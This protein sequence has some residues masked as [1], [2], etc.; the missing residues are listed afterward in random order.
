MGDEHDGRWHLR[1][2][3]KKVVEEEAV[4]KAS[5]LGA[6][7]WTALLNAD[8]RHNWGNLWVWGEPVGIL[9]FL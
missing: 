7:A 4:W 2:K 1:R 5:G 9:S 3:K 6:E 8:Y